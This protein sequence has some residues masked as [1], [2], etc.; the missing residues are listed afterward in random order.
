MQGLLAYIDGIGWWS[1]GVPD[2]EQAARLLRGDDS[3][4]VDASTRPSASV[5]P[6]TERRRAPESVRLA[7]EVAGQACAMA[8]REPSTLA[9]VFASAHGDTATTDALCATLAS[10]PLETSPTRFHNSVHNAPAGYWTIAAQCRAPS[11]AIA[12]GPGSFAAGLFE[13]AVE[14]HA[15]A[16]PVLFAAYD[17]A[18]CGA[19]TDVVG[20]SAPFAAALI[21]SASRG[22]RTCASLYLRH[23]AQAT[24]PTAV[25]A[26]LA[27]LAATNLIAAALPL[28][29]ALANA[30]ETTLRLRNGTQT[31]LAI[32][33]RA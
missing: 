21:V 3:A 12:A 28:F 1:P 30:E 27:A 4:A 2:W 13:A 31:M 29:A 33:V 7:C 22:P 14:A 25:P 24:A 18:A 11:S 5:L 6:P 19:L 8:A 23:E 16:A 17:I 15:D 20:N 32:E 9:C 10:A 26:G